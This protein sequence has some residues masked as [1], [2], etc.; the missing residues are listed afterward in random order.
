ML[1]RI[2]VVTAIILAA[3]VFLSGCDALT[4]NSAENLVRPPKLAG[5]DGELQAAFEKAVGEKGEYILK[6]PSSGEYRSAYV[7]HDCDSDGED[8]AFVFY[9]L[10]AEE[11]SVFVYMLDYQDGEWIAVGENP[12]EGNDV[13]SIE[14]CDLNSDGIDEVFIGWRSLDSKA[15]RKLTV[16]SSDRTSK[17]LA[18]KIIA[19]ETFTAM[20]TVDIDSDSQ[21]EIL[22]ALI[23]STSDA[24]TTQARLLKM[25]ESGLTDY[26]V[27][28]IGEIELYSGIT[29]INSMKTGLSG[30]RRYVYIDETAGDSY[31]T[32]M[33]YWDKTNSILASAFVIDAVSFA[34]C[35][36]SRS[37]PLVCSDVNRD[38]E[39]EIPVTT[40]LEGS[41]VISKSIQDND[42][43]SIESNIYCTSWKKFAEGTFRTVSSYIYNE[44]DGFRLSCDEEFLSDY[45]VKFFPDDSITQIFLRGSAEEDESTLLFTVKKLPH[46]EVADTDYQ[47]AVSDEYTYICEITEN[48]ENEGITTGVIRN[49]FSL[50]VQ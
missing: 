23:N 49:I 34:D 17:N 43:Y 14:F 42:P 39:L 48:G 47:L 45:I 5:S 36:T 13:Y 8:E 10:K 2:L 40:L 32:E 29:A 11:M 21:Q 27:E 28:H 24:Y 19:I 26:T 35:P 22:L 9:S 20:Y 12:G 1:K 6:Y 16:L 50:S 38:G 18:Y 3:A 41:V 4:F 37:L 46:S 44:Y 31:L 30:G 15:N 25:K 33:L 7:R